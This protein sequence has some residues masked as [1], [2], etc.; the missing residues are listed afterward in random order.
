MIKTKKSVKM[1]QDYLL[2]DTFP[3]TLR[4]KNKR[5]HWDKW[6]VDLSPSRA[7]HKQYKNG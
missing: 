1:A 6:L 3:G 4:K 5:T 2:L 7:L